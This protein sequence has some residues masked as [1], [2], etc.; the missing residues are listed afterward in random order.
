MTQ[1]RAE[2]SAELLTASF[3]AI[4]RDRPVKADRFAENGDIPAL[5]CRAVHV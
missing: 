2:W 5:G 3:A 4:K 1:R